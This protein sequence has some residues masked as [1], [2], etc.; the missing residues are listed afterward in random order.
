MQRI[1]VMRKEQTAESR[2][3]VVI[4]SDWL[5]KALLIYEALKDLNIS[6][7]ILCV[8]QSY[9]CRKSFFKRT[10]HLFKTWTPARKILF[11]R[12]LF[13]RKITFAFEGLNSPRALNWLAGIKPDVG[14]HGIGTI[15]RKNA[16]SA[17]S[18]G[19]INPHIG[20]LPEFRGRCV[21]EWSILQG[22]PTGTT[23]FFIDE[24]IDTGSEI[25]DFF[26]S[27]VADFDNIDAAKASLFAQDIQI[28]K[29]SIICL[30]DSSFQPILNDVSLGKRYYVMSLL[31]K[32]VVTNIMLDN[33]YTNTKQD[34]HAASLG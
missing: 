19:I 28:F 22:Q 12:L 2:L 25:I 17:F 13:T 4:L 23:S 18:R 33:S 21:M 8:S 34:S 3:R 15:Y 9:D 5:D 20:K 32:E 16:I 26:P 27:S 29:Q 30:L 10:L 24:G 7:Y 11:C 1:D 6:L 31:M 14:L